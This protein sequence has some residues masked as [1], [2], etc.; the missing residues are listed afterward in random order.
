MGVWE[1]LSGELAAS[2]DREFER[3]SLPILRFFDPNFIQPPMLQGLDRAGI[4]LMVWADGHSFPWGAQCKGF[5]EKDELGDSQVRQAIRSIEK[6]RTSPFHCDRYLLI[7]NRT[8][9]NQEATHVIKEALAQLVNEGKAAKADIWD[10]RLFL[11]QAKHQLRSL[12]VS[13]INEDADRLLRE[14]EELFRF[15]AVYTP[16]V[17]VTALRAAFSAGRLQSVERT[18]LESRSQSIAQIISSP[19]Q[20]RWTLLTG[21]FGS[22]KTT[23]SLHATRTGSRNLIYVRAEAIP[24]QRGGV[25]TNHL[26]GRVIEAMLLFSDLPDETRLL[27]EHLTGRTL[28]EL[29]RAEDTTFVLVIDGLDESRTYSRFDGMHRLTN[30]LAELNCSIVLTTRLEHFYSTFSN[31]EDSFGEISRKGGSRRDGRIYEL[32]PWKQPQIVGYLSEVIKVANETEKRNIEKAAKNLI[33]NVDNGWLRDLPSHPLFL[34][35]I[36]EEASLGNIRSRNR[37]DLIL[38]WIRRK[39]IRDIRTGRR[40][41]VDVTDAETFVRAMIDLHIAV[42]EYMVITEGKVRYLV[43]HIDSDV[44][45]KTACAIFNRNDVEISAIL[46]CSL[47][48]PV[49]PRRWDKMSIRFT[50]RVCQEF[51]VALGLVQKKQ[52]VTGYP[53]TVGELAE[54]IATSDLFP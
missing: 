7:H 30:E 39:I 16:H 51:F 23:T 2:S 53:D 11:S 15:G 37:A 43:E 8:A 13:R 20:A 5:K 28:A 19:S 1:T 41:P 48:T 36:V 35:M 50:L 4:D 47:L 10:R 42:A 44:V 38:G 25:G 9:K 32:Q 34:Q 46:G 54:E 3:R 18:E 21:N 33:D 40:T 17:P 14:Q 27:A 29:L 31:F 49:A 26:L 45:V 12:I 24:D 22:G 6:F 52:P